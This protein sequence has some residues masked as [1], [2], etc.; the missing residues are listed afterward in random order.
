MFP[1]ALAL[2]ISIQLSAQPAMQ[3][4]IKDTLS[5]AESLY[6]E[7]KF[8]ES[9]Q[10]LER[11]NDALRS[12]PERLQDKVQAKL[13][14]ALAHIGMNNTPAARSFLVEIYA[15]E[16]EFGLDT[17]E[18]SPKVITLANEAKT[19]QAA[20]RCRVAGENARKSLS[21]GD[22]AGLMD[23]LRSMR[24]KCADLAAL[25]PAAAE[26]VY[27]DGLADYKK[28]DF[29]HALQKFRETVKLAP[30]HEM[31]AQYVELTESKLQVAEDRALLQWQQQW[32]RN[33]D[34]RQ[35]KQAAADYRQIASLS[36][37]QTLGR[38]NAE[39]RRALIPLVEALNQSCASDDPTSRNQIRTQ[40]SEM[41]PDPSFGEDIRAR[42]V[43]CAPVEAPVEP[44]LFAAKVDAKPA[45]AR[46]EPVAAQPRAVAPSASNSV[47]ALPAAT[48]SAAGCFQMDASLALIRLKSRVDPEIPKESRSYLQN[49]KVTVRVKA[50]IDEGGNVSVSGTEG[51]NVILNNAVRAA[52]E[53]WKFS[54]A[55]D[56]AGP[57]CVDTEI[58][59]VLGR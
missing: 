37:N 11:V 2:I 8:K 30:K 33:F 38:I 47:P 56:Q 23:T 7:A 57:R 34:A 26:L 9:I 20:I 1:Y 50:R 18:F 22:A 44:S 53:R 6:Y 25:E 51:T 55:I 21:L 40:I 10:L 16:P 14:L 17:K 41:L 43:P 36:D 35:F 48:A 49:T 39:Y 52:V 24:P 46:G 19:E 54:P 15:L 42:M 59:V 45:N 13:Q 12:Q 27:K 58:P 4:P 3:D 32:Q 28:G 5:K 31:G 29:F